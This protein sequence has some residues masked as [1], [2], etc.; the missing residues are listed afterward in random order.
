MPDAGPQQPDS[1]EIVPRR[2]KWAVGLAG[3]GSSAA[4]VLIIRELLVASAGNELSISAVLAAWLVW[5]AVGSWLGGLAIAHGKRSPVFHVGAVAAVEV[6]VLGVCLAL[7]RVGPELLGWA[8]GGAL[9]EWGL[10]P[11]QGGT[12]SLPQLLVL[13]TMVTAPAGVLL[14]WQFAAGAALLQ[15]VSPDTRGLSVA[16]VADSLGHLVGGVVLSVPLIIAVPPEVSLAIAC[17]LVVA[18]VAMLRERAR[19]RR[20][21]VVALIAVGLLVGAKH[22]REATLRVRWAPHWVLDSRDGPAG[23]LTVLQAESEELSYW[24]NGGHAFE[25]GQGLAGEQWVDIPLLAHES[26]RR[27]LLI[28]GGPRTLRQVLGHGP[29]RVTYFEFDPVMIRAIRDHAPGELVAALDD[30]RVTTVLGD[31]RLHIPAMLRAGVQLDVILVALPD[32]TTAQL[33]RYYTVEWFRKA[34]ALMARGAVLGFQVM[35]S[36]DYLSEDLRRYNACLFHTAR[37]GHLIAS[38]F[39]GPRATILVSVR[40]DQ[41]EIFDDYPALEERILDRGMDP[42]TVLASFYDALDPFRR[43]DR[44]REIRE[45]EDVR[46]NRDFAPTCYYY[47][48]VLWAGWWEGSTARLLRW[49]GELTGPRVLAAAGAL[50]VLVGLFSRVRK[51]PWR[52]VAPYGVFIAGASGMV[53]EV[54]LLLALQSLYGYVY[55][56]VGYAVGVLMAGLAGGAWLAHRRVTRPNARKGLALAMAGIAASAVL[57]VVV[58]FGLQRAAL[59]SVSSGLLPIVAVSLLMGATGVAVGAAFPAAL[60]ALQEG[61]ESL[62]GGTA[63]YATDLVGACGGAFLAGLILI[64][65]LGVMSTC[66]MVVVL[67]LGA[68]ALAAATRL[69]A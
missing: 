54:V 51:K 52:V 6:V 14:G 32:P 55:G 23:N 11:I 43:E 8:F 35:S 25:T 19:G 27:V 56:V 49:A 50:T 42:P 40:G 69:E 67:A 2:A 60:A 47:A 33:N 18:G 53:L 29:E 62:R 20:L 46:L 63:L 45:T 44:Q 26:P 15:S 31:A 10:A 61:P 37:R 36:G 1:T 58:L 22:F 38:V 13:T 41:A 65:L 3:V 30:P 24:A 39:P 64:P 21:I 4:Q 59:Y 28:G 12:L 7:S 68:G 34:K 5:S 66:A 48:Q 16:Y 17:M 9:M 57:S